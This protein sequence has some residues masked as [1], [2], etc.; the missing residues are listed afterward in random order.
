MF[1]VVYLVH[2]RFNHA[3]RMTTRRFRKVPVLHLSLRLN[4][5]FSV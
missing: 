2:Y 4:Y 3:N 5:E 1:V